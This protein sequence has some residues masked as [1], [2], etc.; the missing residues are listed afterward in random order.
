MAVITLSKQYGSGGENIARRV[1][2]ITG[3]R[4]FDKALMAQVAH[5]EGRAEGEV[6][7]YSED[8]PT[9]RSFWKR[10]FNTSTVSEARFW[11]EG[12]HGC[13]GREREKA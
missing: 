4:Y 5:E 11:E 3:Y 9:I 2:E 1:Y 6:I 12:C 10:L 8:S 13:Q 7:D